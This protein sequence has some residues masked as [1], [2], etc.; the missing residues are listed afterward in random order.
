MIPSLGLI[1]RHRMK[2]LV[3]LGVLVEITERRFVGS[4]DWG[5]HCE[6]LKRRRKPPGPHPAR[7]CLVSISAWFCSAE[8]PFSWREGGHP[9]RQACVISTQR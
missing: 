4:L 5:W 8:T 3:T 1:Y 7:L 6:S 2:A 9:E